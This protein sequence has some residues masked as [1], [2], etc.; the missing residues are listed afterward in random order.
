MDGCAQT[1]DLRRGGRPGRGG[2]RAPARRS[3]SG[4]EHE[5]QRANQGADEQDSHQ[6]SRNVRQMPPAS[7]P[8][9]ERPESGSGPEW[10]LVDGRFFQVSGKRI[11]SHQALLYASDDV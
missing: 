8:A 1:I 7:G 6:I 3:P 5:N 11:S 2:W 10:S 4:P 9:Q